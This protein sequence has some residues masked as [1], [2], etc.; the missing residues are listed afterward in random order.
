MANKLSLV[1][2]GTKWILTLDSDPSTG[3]GFDAPI[4][5]EALV[6][7]GGVG[8][9]WAKYGAATTA[10][11]NLYEGGGSS[12]PLN[13]FTATTNPSVSNDNTQGY[14]VGSEWINT[15]T[16][17]EY[18]CMATTTGAAVWR[19]TISANGTTQSIT[20][21]SIITPARSDCKIDTKA[22]L[23]TYVSTATNGQFCF[24][25][26]EKM[27]YM[28]ID[29]V[30]VPMGTPTI[31]PLTSSANA[32]AIDMKLYDNFSHTLTQN[33]TLQ[34]PSNM[35]PGRG[36][37]ISFTQSSSSAFT[38]SLVASY[39]TTDGA[40]ITMPTTLGSKADLVYY[41][42][43]ASYITCSFFKYGVS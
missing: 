9:Q 19:E 15:S 3:G 29:A 41:I 17:V 2:V 10:W 31:S 33:T 35:T 26:D 1:T 24:A 6:V 20:N 11:R 40:V 8:S 34:L 13:N 18:V 5:S 4:G 7:S 32:I 39:K 36:G 28:V 27:Y 16:G 23:L 14:V 42:D 12:G 25:S 21:K 30:L 22:N 43:S 38:L 37:V